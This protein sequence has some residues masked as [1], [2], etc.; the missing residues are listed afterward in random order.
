[1]EIMVVHLCDLVV[2][3]LISSRSSQDELVELSIRE[4][5]VIFV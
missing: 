4:A 3:N 5:K 2:E 1:M